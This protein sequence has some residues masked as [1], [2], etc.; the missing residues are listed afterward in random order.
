MQFKI[1]EVIATS[2]ILGSYYTNSYKPKLHED[3][4]QES[5]IAA[6]SVSECSLKIALRAAR[7][8]SCRIT[9]S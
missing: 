1:Q 8:L 2:R 4:T 6:S 7:A 3:L 9:Q 5:R